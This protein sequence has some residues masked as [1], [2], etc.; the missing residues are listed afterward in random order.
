[1]KKEYDFSKGKRVDPSRVDHD[2]RVMISIRINAFVLAELKQ[3]AETLGVGYQTL[4]SNI[5]G[6]HV[7]R[8]SLSVEEKLLKKILDR[9]DEM[10]SKRKKKA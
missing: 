6:R 5:L 3:Q 7:G 9:L 8:S 1:M 2:P 10:S 4:I